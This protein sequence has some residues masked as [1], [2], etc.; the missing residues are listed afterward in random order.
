MSFPFEEAQSAMRLAALD[1]WLMWL[2][3]DGNPI[4]ERLLQRP[5]GQMRSRRAYYWIPA[6]GHPVRLEHRIEHHTLDGLPGECRHYLSHESHVEELAALTAGAKRIA[7]ETSP[8]AALPALSLVDAGTV[9]LLRSLGLEVCSSANLVQAVQPRLTAVQLD[10]HLR[11]AALVRDIALATVEHVA[12]ALAMGARPTEVEAQE[13]ILAAFAQAGLET[14][15][16]PIVAV[17]AHAGNPHH[18]PRAGHVIERD[19]VLLIDLWARFP[20]EGAVYADQTWMAFTGSQPPQELQEAWRLVRDARR[21]VPR[22]VAERMAQGLPVMGWEADIAARA[23]IQAAGQGDAFLHRT[24][25]SIDTEV[26]GRGANLDG[27]ETRDERLLLPGSVMSV[28]PGL[29]YPHFG[30]RSENN[31]VITS[32]GLVLVAEGTDQEDLLLMA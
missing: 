10:S 24:G 9:D 17:G 25:H 28:E 16:A 22:L 32:E 3:H 21:A 20:E 27:L 7:M 4:A 19:Q 26:H 11:A 2:L 6:K 15:H 30:V 23:V 29:Y 1:G 18:E 31:L 5:A 12:Q 8:M 14:D 13:F